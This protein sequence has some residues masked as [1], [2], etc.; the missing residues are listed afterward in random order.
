MYWNMLHK[1]I[2]KGKLE[3]VE[4]IMERSRVN[5]QSTIRISESVTDK[6]G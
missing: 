3:V 6:V 2:L 4:F 1:N 5:I